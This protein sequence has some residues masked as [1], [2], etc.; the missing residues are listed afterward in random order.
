MESINTDSER[1]DKCNING[2]CSPIT[3]NES[4][5]F[6]HAKNI[7]DISTPSELKFD[8]GI[9][10]NYVSSINFLIFQ[11]LLNS[12]HICC[13]YKPFSVKTMTIMH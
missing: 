9:V 3:D 6:N 7:D 12:T 13:F 5:N 8:E 10:N 2:D 1:S 11:F 4:N